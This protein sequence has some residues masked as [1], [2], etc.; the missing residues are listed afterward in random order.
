M[1]LGSLLF[2]WL[3]F[4]WAI[5]RS[6]KLN[7]IGEME[8]RQGDQMRS[9]KKCPKCS[10]TLFM[11]FYGL[12]TCV[13]YKNLPKVGKQW[14]TRRKFAQSGHPERRR[15]FLEPLSEL[16]WLLWLRWSNF[17]SYTD[18]KRKLVGIIAA[19]TVIFS[20]NNILTQNCGLEENSL[21]SRPP[22]WNF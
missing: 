21:F 3:R 5:L 7:R 11:S 10:P 17:L 4:E 2:R 15:Q 6:D 1:Y 9:W 22:F 18:L 20:H 8:R 14:R 13:I 19:S 12:G 16:W